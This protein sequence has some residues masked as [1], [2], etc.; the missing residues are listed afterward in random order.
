M[1]ARVADEMPVPAAV[2]HLRSGVADR[3]PQPPGVRA[4]QRPAADAAGITFFEN[5][6]RPILVEHCYRCHGPD[7]GDGKAELRVDSLEALLQGWRLRSGDRS[8]RTG[9]SLLILAVRH[10]GDVSMPPKKKLAQP[11]SMRSPPGSR[12]GLRG[13]PPRRSRRRPPDH[14]TV[15]RM[16]RIGAA[17]LGVPDARGARRR[18]RSSMRRWP[19]SPDR[20]LHPGAA[21]GGR[22]ASGAAGRQADA[23]AAGDARP[24]GAFPPRP[25]KSTRSCATSLAQAFERRRRPPARVAAIRRALGPALAG[26]RPLRRQQR[27]GR[28]PRLL[29]RLA[30]SR[31]RDRA[32]STPT[33]RSTGSSRSRSPATCSPKRSRRGATS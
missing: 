20:P 3:R 26:R 12:W 29:R 18:R 8:R 22:A 17:V 10:D 2:A 5:K 14:G 21:R 33:S 31:L 32:R 19:R 16:G 6:V 1:F 11:R 15:P 24:A 30:L 23:A 25:R 27:H 13:P 28:Q 7:S 4:T 9:R